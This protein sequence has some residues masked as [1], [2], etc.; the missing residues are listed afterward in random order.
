MERSRLE[1]HLLL[2]DFVLKGGSINYHRKVFYVCLFTFCHL[3][4]SFYIKQAA[5]QQF[6]QV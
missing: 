1:L 4:D 6:K 5:P 2:N 3:M